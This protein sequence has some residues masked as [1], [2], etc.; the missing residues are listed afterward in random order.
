MLTP[1][2]HVLAVVLA[3]LF[4]LRARFFG[5]ARLQRA[6]SSDL[7]RVRMSVYRGAMITQW[8]LTAIAAAIWAWERRDWHLL[9]LQPVVTGGLVG[10]LIGL[11]VVIFVVV[12]QRARGLGEEQTRATLRKRM[13]HLER[14]MPRTPRELRVFYLLSLTA[15]LCEEFLYRGWLIWYLQAL[16]LALIPAAAV[17][18][19]VFGIGHVY[20][21]VRGIVLT[22]VVGAFLAAVYLISQSLYAGMLV[23]T[24]MDANSGQ[25]LYTVYRDDAERAARAEL[26]DSVAEVEA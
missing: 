10:I 16:G 2:D 7:P 26:G 15:G 13:A 22:T 14:M 25:L 1:L 19:L 6:D 9:G 21:G 23:H 3:V 11:G 5:F 4:P 20:Q 17:S 18:S 24:L 8:T 12:R